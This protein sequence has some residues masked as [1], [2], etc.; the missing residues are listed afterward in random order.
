[1]LFGPFIK[2]R[3]QGS[4]FC[5]HEICIQAAEMIRALLASY[6]RLYSLRRTPSFVPI[7]TLASPILYI[8]QE[9]SPEVGVPTQL[10][11][12]VGNLREIGFSHK[13][14]VRRAHVL[15]T[16]QAHMPIS[17][18][19]KDTLTGNIEDICKHI[20]IAKKVLWKRSNATF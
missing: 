18:A 11:Q 20:H 4:F 12:G 15:A 3:F 7:I 6:R 16:V 9:E 14:A 13:E 17:P 1:M 2:F 19:E 8:V 5:P 10:S